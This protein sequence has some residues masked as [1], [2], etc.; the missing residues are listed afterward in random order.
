MKISRIRILNIDRFN[1]QEQVKKI[2]AVAKDSRL[3]YPKTK[4]GIPYERYSFFGADGGTRTR[5]LLIT[6]QLLYQLSH[7]SV[8]FTQRCY[9]TID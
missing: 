4:E 9:Y 3:F 2:A 5:D 1:K 7:I 6:N 8:R